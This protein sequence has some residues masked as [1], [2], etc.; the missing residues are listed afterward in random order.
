MQVQDPYLQELLTRLDSL[1]NAAP[2]SDTK[3][4]K[5]EPSAPDS[6]DAPPLAE[7]LLQA[8][9]VRKDEPSLKK[10]TADGESKDVDFFPPAPQSLDEAG[11]CET[12]VESLIL[13][14]LL[15]RSAAAG[16]AISDQVGLPF[17]LVEPV[18]GRLKAEHLVVYRSAA[19]FGDYHYQ[20]TEKGLAA[21]HRA[22]TQGRYFGTAPVPFEDYLV[23][24]CAAEHQPAA[25]QDGRHS[26]RV[27]GHGTRSDAA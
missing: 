10:P 12:L 14:L 6:E 1:S 23:A 25:P 26:G 19:A 20:L 24:V 5:C 3:T 22:L 9:A 7:A 27:R 4:S 8:A 2:P 11:I 13:K 16:R 21:G 18:L 15:H 17:G